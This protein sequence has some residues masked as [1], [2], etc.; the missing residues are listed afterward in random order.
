MKTFHTPNRNKDL[1]K[2]F[3][4]IMFL[5][6]TGHGNM[7]L[8]EETIELVKAFNKTKL[9]IEKSFFGKT[10]IFVP[11]VFLGLFFLIDILSI[12]SNTG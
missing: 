6:I 10:I 5:N 11:G 12:I 2:K 1:K 9:E 8:G 3:A 7:S 4:R